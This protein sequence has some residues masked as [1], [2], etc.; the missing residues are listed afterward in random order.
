MKVESFAKI[1][2]GL[3]VVRR[4]PDGFHEIRTLFQS[5]GLW[6]TL[7]FLPVS[8]SGIE[9][10]GSDTNISWG[11]DNLIHRAAA[12]LARTYALKK[13]AAIRVVKNIPPGRG[14]GGGSSNAAMTLWALNKLW[15]LG[16]ERR[17]LMALGAGLG[18]DVPYFLEG[19]LCLGTGRGEEIRPLED[20]KRCHVLLVFPRL[21]V[22]TA[23]IYGQ[24]R[25]TLT[26]RSK[27]SKIMQFLES[28]DLHELDN[29]L[30]ETI[31]RFYPLIKE[32]KQRLHDLGSE[33][34]L[35]SGSGSAVIGLFSDLR[36]AR[37]AWR[38]LRVDTRVC[39]VET[40]SRGRYWE[41]V[42]AG[43]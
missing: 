4:R 26:S 3:E 15:G 31:F 11:E 39:L 9:L 17:E 36:V 24:H 42:T 12:L 18:S 22:S 32:S 14:L 38:T 28:P 43:V 5:I 40:L 41:S 34:S 6:D 1:N 25:A 35:V 29:D 16:L 21:S 8:G 19:G 20:L 10:T 7:E 2:L 33:L 13:G 27:D 23:F 37:Q 30:E